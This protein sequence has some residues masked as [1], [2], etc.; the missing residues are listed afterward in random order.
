MLKHLRELTEL[1]GISG[2]EETVRAYI[3]RVVEESPA[4]T[5]M[6]VD[7]LGNLLVEVTGAKR[8]ARRLMLEAHM[9]EVGLI[10]T[11]ITEEGYLRFATV[12]GIDDKVLAGQC[13]L[14]NGLTGVIGC[15]AMHLCSKEERAKVP[16]A[17]AMVIDIGAADRAEAEAHV[18]PGDAVVFDTAFTAMG[19]GRFHAKALDDRVGCAL[20]LSLLEQP[21]PYDLTLVFAVQEEVGLRGATTAAYTVQP[22]VS[23]T[24]EAT[25]ASDIGGTPAGREVCFVGRGAVLSFMDGRTLYDKALYDEIMALAAAQ[26]IPVQPKTAVAG[27]N[28]AGAIQGAGRGTRVAAISLPC[29]YIHSPVCVLAEEDVEA[30]RRLVTALAETLP[31]QSE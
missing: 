10:V 28:D 16:E 6:T 25:T 23:V 19:D 5:H 17:S 27:G 30:A 11:G 2:R 26:H 18:A 4:T 8:P 1:S 24:V 22:D 3:R 21:L 20:L 12:G 13:V 14:V 29:R 31:A 7:P 9:D 15:R